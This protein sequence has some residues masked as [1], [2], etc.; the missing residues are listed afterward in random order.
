MRMKEGGEFE[1]AGGLDFAKGTHFIRLPMAG[2]E[3]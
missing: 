2:S 1:G 3:N